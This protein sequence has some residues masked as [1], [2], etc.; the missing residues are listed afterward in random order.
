MQA[1]VVLTISLKGMIKKSHYLYFTPLLVLLSAFAFRSEEPLKPA[2]V[3]EALP[4]DT[5]D[6]VLVPG[7]TFQMGSF[8]FSNERPVHEVRLDSFY[9]GKYEVTVGEYQK[10]C[11]ET[12]TDMPKP[13]SWGWKPNYPIVNVTYQDAQKYAK[14][15]GKRL[16]TEAEWEYAAKGGNKTHNYNYSGANLPAAVGWSF[17]NSFNQAQP[18]GMK[19]PNELGIYD[20]SG[21]VWEWCA[22]YY[23][24]YEDGRVEN[25]QGPEH[26]INRVLRGGSWFD[27]GTNL[28]VAN[29][30]YANEGTKD[31]LTGFRVAMD[32]P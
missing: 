24:P 22:D 7:G 20:M 10:F 4:L 12:G 11:E 27:K 3:P 19:R 26:G 30:Y 2:P 8:A 17:E 1:F 32:A 31:Q 16:P 25:P 6:M 18:V 28:R 29:R 9:I 23:A 13:P 15:V 5:A 21:N 14:W